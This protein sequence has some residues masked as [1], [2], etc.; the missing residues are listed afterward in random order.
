MPSAAAALP[1]SA[2]KEN[3]PAANVIENGSGVT[4]ETEGKE[5]K[6]L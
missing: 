1:L 4:V 6:A 3:E 2:Q 5:P